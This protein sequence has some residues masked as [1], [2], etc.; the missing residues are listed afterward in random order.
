MV[1]LADMQA[2]AGI[3]LQ[4]AGQTRQ[5]EMPRLCAVDVDADQA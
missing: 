5:Q 2:D 3:H 1:R 4:E